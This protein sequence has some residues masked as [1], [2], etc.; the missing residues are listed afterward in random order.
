[1]VQLQ[2]IE[3]TVIIQEDLL[4]EDYRNEKI[5]LVDAIYIAKMELTG[6]ESDLVEAQKR[7]NWEKESE[8]LKQ[9]FLNLG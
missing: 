4:Y 6:S 9:V 1:M 7:Y 2:T 3:Q 8:K 5:A